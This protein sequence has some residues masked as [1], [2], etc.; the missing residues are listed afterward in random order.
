[1]LLV[2]VVWLTRRA[3]RTDRTRAAFLL[4]GGW[5]VLTGLLFSYADGII[6]P[7]YTVALAPA[8][9]ALVGMG[10]IVL[11]RRR[12]EWFCRVA[13][14]VA[15]VGAVVWA[16]VL[17]ERSPTWYPA[18]RTAILVIGLVIAALVAVV[19]RWRGRLAL[20]VGGAAVVVALAGP[21]A[22][23][24]QT[25]ATTHQ[26]AIPSAGPTT[27]GGPGG[28]AG[29][30][31]PGGVG[32]Q[33][34]SVGPGGRG[35]FGPGGFPGGASGPGGGGAS[36]FGAPPSGGFG[37]GSRST[38]STGSTGAAGPSGSSAGGLLNGS[39]PDV[40]LVRYLETDARRYP[41]V[42]A[43]VG[44]DSASGYQLATDDPVMAIGGFNGTDPAPT[45]VQFEQDV[46]EKKVHYFIAGGSGVGPGF[47]GAGG[48]GRGSSTSD[49]A[50]RI[51]SWV[52]SHFTARTVGGVTVYDLSSA[53]SG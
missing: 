34:G 9:A 45:L 35:G 30:G 3:P 53:A 46:Q 14:A 44:A 22:Y 31:G 4:W 25:A 29:A 39:T 19:P 5:L 50:D 52:E 10:A 6:H 8:V 16:Y 40:A 26:G 47:A 49:D 42:A 32:G 48:G 51:T 15:L 11:W 28:F 17:L 33:G 21:A 27:G 2:A 7:Y 38:G 13:L 24:L 1:M 23:S 20:A 41:W 12:G 18:L 36:G 43:T 37:P